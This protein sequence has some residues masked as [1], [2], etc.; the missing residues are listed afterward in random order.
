MNDKYNI[1]FLEILKQSLE[2][3][4]LSVEVEELYII[5]ELLQNVIQKILKEFKDIRFKYFI[6][7]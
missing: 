5:E 6:S 7:R 2:V 3:L 1:S 4:I